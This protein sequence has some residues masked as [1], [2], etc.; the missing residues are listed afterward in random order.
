MGFK[1]NHDRDLKASV[2]RTATSLLE[3]VRK[4][5]AR[6]GDRLSAASREGCP[7]LRVPAG[8]A[9][10]SEGVLVLEEEKLPSSKSPGCVD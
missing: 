6:V 5:P 8:A 4:R 10:E 2:C 7:S 1:R 3:S 9:F